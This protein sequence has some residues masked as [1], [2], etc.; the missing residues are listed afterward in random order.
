MQSLWISLPFWVV[1]ILHIRHNDGTDPSG[2]N[3]VAVEEVK[4]IREVKTKEATLSVRRR[5]DA[6]V[7]TKSAEHERAGRTSER[8]L[9][10]EL[11]KYYLLEE[12]QKGWSRIRLPS[13]GKHGCDQ[14]AS[15]I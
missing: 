6:E 1:S 4:K 3:A 10:R 13:V 7:Q 14:R 12:G 11:S 9:F 8:G 15:D 5:K 2:C